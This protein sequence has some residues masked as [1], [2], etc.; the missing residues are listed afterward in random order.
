MKGNVVAMTQIPNE[1]AKPP[2]MAR[3]AKCAVWK[4]L[5][6]AL[7]ESISDGEAAEAGSDWQI[8]MDQSC[9]AY[10]LMLLEDD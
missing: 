5:Q 2:I 1:S 6:M 8:D 10:E 4:N 9:S 3:K 7:D